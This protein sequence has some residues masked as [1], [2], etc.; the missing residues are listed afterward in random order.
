LTFN[1]K[2]AKAFFSIDTIEGLQ[3]VRLAE[4]WNLQRVDGILLVVGWERGSVVSLLVWRR[5]QKK[6]LDQERRLPTKYRLAPVRLLFAPRLYP[7]LVLGDQYGQTFCPHA[8]RSS[9]I[10]GMTRH[11]L[12]SEDHRACV[13][14]DL[15][16]CGS[17]YQDTSKDHYLCFRQTHCRRVKVRLAQQQHSALHKYQSG[18]ISLVEQKQNLALSG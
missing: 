8:C 9:R 12:R 15:E 10:E 16:P 14:P 2:V 11:D 5:Y 4:G 6:Q 7:D 17:I 18:S 13:S 3:I 1:Q